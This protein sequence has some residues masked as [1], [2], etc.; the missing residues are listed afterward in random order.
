MPL[1]RPTFCEID[2]G[3]L[4]HNF[5]ELKKR[6]GVCEILTVVKA[7]AYGHGALAV[8]RALVAEGALNLG[9]ATIEEGIELRKAGI[10]VPILCLGG[11]LG[12]QGS[13]F[14]EHSLTPVVFNE[15]A[16]R[17]LA[18]TLTPST[19][20][21]GIHLKVD[22]GMGRLGVFPSQVTSI[23]KTIQESSQLELKGV[24]TH[25]ARA[26]EPE[27]EPTQEQWKKF[28]Q[29][30]DAVKE[31]GFACPVFHVAN[32][33]ALIEGKLDNTQMV[34]PGLALYGAYP[35]PR[36][37]E[38]IDL[39]PVMAWKTQI[40]SLK[41]FPKGSPIS[42]SATFKTTRES[43][44]GVIATGYADGYSRLFSNRGEAL[45]KGKRVPVVGRVCMD[46]TML[47]LTD[48]VPVSL[49]EEVVLLGSQGT[50]RI[51]AEEMAEKIGT[52][53]YEIF[54]SISSRVPR[55]AVSG[56]DAEGE[57]R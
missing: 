45:V 54:C 4:R 42:Y 15:E 52:I 47:D 40:I 39:K 6:A 26:D 36:F 3:A 27:P 30:E 32:S 44:I 24:M 10:S 56:N 49:E 28:R 23:L 1:F 20:P 46:L 19:S 25:L 48:V 57:K 55:I 51:S 8:A 50:E 13:D 2:L 37:R 29:V 22:T 34:R 31:A 33:A 7:N 14:Q 11:P 38:K 21:F 43:W 12:A 17:F 18:Q 5:R 9:V 16:V 41:K 53:S 35:H